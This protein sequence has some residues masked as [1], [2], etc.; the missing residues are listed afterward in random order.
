VYSFSDFFFHRF[1]LAI[2]CYFV[3]K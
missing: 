3:S 2:L 1:A